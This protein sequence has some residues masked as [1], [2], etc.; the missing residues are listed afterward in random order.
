[1]AHEIKLAPN[2]NEIE[3]DGNVL[4]CEFNGMKIRWAIGDDC[5][6]LDE[7]TEHSLKEWLQTAIG[8]SGKMWQVPFILNKHLPFP[9]LV[10]V[11]DKVVDYPK[12]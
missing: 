2:L 9:S 7:K 3:R 5:S 11:N 4:S 10:Y 6:D 1:M 12:E 8:M